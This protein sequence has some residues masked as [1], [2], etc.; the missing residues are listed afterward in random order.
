MKKLLGVNKNSID[1][2]VGGK[3]FWKVS[4]NIAISQYAGLFYFY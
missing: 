2:Y 3:H 1:M 4:T